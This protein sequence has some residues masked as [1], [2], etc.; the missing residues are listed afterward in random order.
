MGNGI[1]WFIKLVD[2]KSDPS[3]K[4]FN[5]MLMLLRVLNMP[6]LPAIYLHMFSSTA[7]TCPCIWKFHPQPS[8]SFQRNGM[9]DEILQDSGTKI[10]DS[11]GIRDLTQ[12]PISFS[13]VSILCLINYG[14]AE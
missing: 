7:F 9:C 6:K 4:L 12:I 5:Y 1:W 11:G 14:N 2:C 13:S 10:Q 3:F 8:Y